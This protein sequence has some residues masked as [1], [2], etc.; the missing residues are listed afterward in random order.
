MTDFRLTIFDGLRFVKNH[1]IPS[2]AQRRVR[3]VSKICPEVS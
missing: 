3:I 2:T 1:H